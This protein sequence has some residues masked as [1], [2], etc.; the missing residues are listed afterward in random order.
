MGLRKTDHIGEVTVLLG[1][2]VLFF[3]L[4]KT[5]SYWRCCDPTSEVTVNRGLTIVGHNKN[6]IKTSAYP[7]ASKRSFQ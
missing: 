1:L 7:V 3:A 5:F 2:K 4:W 6:I